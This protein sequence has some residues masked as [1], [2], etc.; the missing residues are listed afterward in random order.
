MALSM[1][2]NLIRN[3]VSIFYFC[4]FTISFGQNKISHIELSNKYSICRYNLI[5][6]NVMYMD[7][8]NNIIYLGRDTIKIISFADTI[9]LT[10]IKGSPNIN[11]NN[12][13]L[14]N[15]ISFLR[16][17]KKL[18]L[19][20]YFYIKK[21]EHDIT[22][23]NEKS[24]IYMNL[25]GKSSAFISISQGDYD[26]VFDLRDYNKRIND[27][28]KLMDISTLSSK[29]FGVD[30]IVHSTIYILPIANFRNSKNLVTV[31]W[32]NTK[33]L[34]LKNK[35]KRKKYKYKTQE[36]VSLRIM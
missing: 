11:Y 36:G 31:F 30:S 2:E 32:D 18:Y 14:S 22:I 17:Y 8:N 13:D 33:Y 21:S 1:I 12:K 23:F 6:K 5:S 25:E 24:N 15:D 16:N 4:I 3:V 19:S 20:E 34:I 35:V 9:L 27:N 7:S 10:L 29:Y 28:F 26:L